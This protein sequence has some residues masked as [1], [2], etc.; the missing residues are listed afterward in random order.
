MPRCT[1]SLVRLSRVQMRPHCSRRA[2]LDVPSVL[3]L[4]H[5]LSLL[6]S[7]CH[8]EMHMDEH[9]VDLFLLVEAYLSRTHVDQKKQSTHD[10]QDLEEIVL[11]KI[12][13]W[14]MWV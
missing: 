7:P 1:V 9:L 8:F 5:I 4:M 12:L 6:L 3:R 13:V 14:V 10:R 11:G 2:R